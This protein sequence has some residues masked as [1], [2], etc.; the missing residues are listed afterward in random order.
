M[1]LWGINI[2]LI[3]FLGCFERKTIVNVTGMH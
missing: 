3:H 2:L 1:L